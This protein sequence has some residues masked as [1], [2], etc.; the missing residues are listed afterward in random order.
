VIA[1]I[2]DMRK[3]VPPPS[4][5]SIVVE[6]MVPPR[7]SLPAQN[8]KQSQSRGVS[9]VM[10]SCFANVRTSVASDSTEGGN[11]TAPLTPA[12]PVKTVNTPKSHVPANHGGARSRTHK[13]HDP[14]PPP[15]KDEVQKMCDELCPGYKYP[16]SFAKKLRVVG[17]KKPEDGRVSGA[18]NYRT[19][20]IENVC[21]TTEDK[22]MEEFVNGIVA[23]EVFQR[24]SVD[25]A[26]RKSYKFK[27]L[28]C[29]TSKLLDPEVWPE[30]IGC[31][32]WQ[33]RGGSQHI[34]Q[35]Q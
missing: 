20:F 8:K 16:P 28:A 3:A 12:A 26:S 18:P 22:D 24:A 31:R 6:Q 34:Q 35:Q 9:R 10:S 29:D 33:F 17:K 30:G 21:K 32:L 4:F 27:V 14:G 13:W 25:E 5:S 19:M 11:N 1:D 23:T 2:S 7:A 15:T